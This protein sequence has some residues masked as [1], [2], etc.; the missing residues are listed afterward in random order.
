DHHP[1]QVA[2]GGGA[3]DDHGVGG[4]VPADLVG[5][6]RLDVEDL[7]GG[8]GDAAARVW[9]PGGPVAFLG[10]GQEVGGRDHADT[11]AF[12]VQDGGAADARAAQPARYLVEGRALRDAG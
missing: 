2:Q 12:L 5:G 1:G 10:P 9:P 8:A 6:Q 11:T 3:A 7:P 4:H